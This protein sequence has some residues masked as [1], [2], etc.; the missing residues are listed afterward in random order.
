MAFLSPFFISARLARRDNNISI[1][2]E[3]ANAVYAAMPEEPIGLA[4]LVKLAGL[5]YGRTVA[6]IG[7]LRAQKRIVDVGAYTYRRT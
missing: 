5:G 3:Y 7:V 6:A 2:A 1:G 4:S